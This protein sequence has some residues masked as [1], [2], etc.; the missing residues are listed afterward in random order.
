MPPKNS[1]KTVNSCFQDG[2]Q[3]RTPRLPARGKSISRR[4]PGAPRRED[5]AGRT[6]GPRPA[7]FPRDERRFAVWAA[8]RISARVNRGC[9]L[10]GSPFSCP[11][12]GSE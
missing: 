1:T 4:F 12:G 2:S 8:L 5:S 11:G 7:D 3:R 6:P 9:P 10:A